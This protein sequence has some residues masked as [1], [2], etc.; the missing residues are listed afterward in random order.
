MNEPLRDRTVWFWRGATCAAA[1]VFLVLCLLAARRETPTIDEF[2]HLPAGCNYW[3]H[4]QLILYAKNPPLLRFWMA[5]PVVADSRV[6]VPAFS[7]NPLAWGPWEY[8]QKFMEANRTLYFEFFFRARMMIVLL[9]LA[10]GALIYLWARRLL[11]E[12]AAAVA[13]SLFFCSPTA[14]AHSHLATVDIGCTFTIL[15]ACLAL[16]WACRRGGAAAMAVLGLALGVALAVKFTALLIV[17][18]ALVLLGWS[19]DAAHASPGRRAALWARDGAIVV[20]AALLVVNASYGFK[21][22]FARLDSHRFY[23]RFCLAVQ[24]ALPGALPVPVPRDYLVGFDAVKRDTESGEEFGSYLRGD[25]SRKGWWYYNLVARLVK[26]RIPVLLLAIAGIAMWRRTGVVAAENWRIILPAA[27]LYL[28]LSVF[29][30]SDTGI[31]YVLPLHPF[32][33][34]ATGAVFAAWGGSGR[35]RWKDALAAF[36]LVTSPVTAIAAYPDEL[37]YFNAIAGGTEHGHEWLLDSNLDWGQ[38]LYRVRE[39]VSR[40]KP[41]GPIGLLYCGHVDPGLYGIEY[42]PVPPEPVED[43]L[44]VSVNF[45][46]GMRYM[47]PAPG[48]KIAWVKPDHL[49]WLKAY[50]P[51]E[52]LGSIWIYDTRRPQGAGS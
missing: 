36:V 14:I 2:A 18:A 52:R 6:V 5:L 40:L 9:G 25:W 7:G 48:G 4:G 51:V 41:S 31:R 50:K 32:L 17:P 28:F 22:S 42:Y 47:A 19:R 24:G 13:A 39:A 3:K 49:A 8:G 12:R 45:V 27:S 44:A 23:S 35:W 46:M 1:A 10:T 20:V 26:T 38:D 30:R 37:A 21:G 43:V 29:N 11:G 16:S 33:H 34:L 15:V